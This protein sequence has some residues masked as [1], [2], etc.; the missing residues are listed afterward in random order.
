MPHA[1]P[2]QRELQRL[3]HGHRLRHLPHGGQLQIY[4]TGAPKGIFGTYTT[5]D[6]LRVAVVDGVVQYSR[7]GIVFYTSTKTPTYPLLVDTALY[8]QGATLV[9]VVLNSVAPPPPPPPPYSGA[10]V[11]TA[12]VG[13]TVNG[14]SLTKTATTGWG[15]AG[16][17]ST[18]QITSGDGYVELTASETNTRRMLGLS[19]GNSNVSYTDIDFALYLYEDELRIY[20]AGAAKG[21]FGTYTT[22]D[23]LRVAVVDGVVQYSRNGTVFYTS[24]GTPTYPLLVDTALY[25]TGATL[26]DVV[27]DTAAPP[28]PPPPFTGAVVWTADVGVTVD[29]NSL[30][31]TATTGWG[32]A[33]AVS[34]QQIT[35]GDGYVEFTASETTTSRML[36]LSNGDSNAS[37]T[38]IDFA[39]YLYGG[40]LRIYE[41]GAARGIFGAFT[42]GDT[43]RVAVVDGVVQY[44]RNGTVLYTSAGTPTYPLLVDT[45]LYTT[46]ATLVDVVIDTA[47]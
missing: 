43:L 4:E 11:W 32:N 31:K 8:T 20:E 22:G 12:V 28:P 34:T 30:T 44:S 17:V 46:G 24:A 35:A 16:A 21:I 37:Y 13:V 36:G 38:D 45:A 42:T 19:N 33:G 41:A 15:N 7:N 10:V 2:L 14:N 47:P 29:G 5:G 27:I 26:V 39:L 1:R 3:L 6:T 18:Q 9:D 40:Q 23:T 25:T